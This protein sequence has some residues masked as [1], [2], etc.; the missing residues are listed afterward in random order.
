MFTITKVSKAM[1]GFFESIAKSRVNSVLLGMGREK[2][3]AFGYSYD[4]LRLGPDAWPWRQTPQ[5]STK[6]III[7][8]S[9]K[10]VEALNSESVGAIPINIGNSESSSIYKYPGSAL[11]AESQKRVA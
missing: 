10:K 11:S 2:V 7:E 4:A 1:S 3:E 8:R 6:E 5:N 9:D